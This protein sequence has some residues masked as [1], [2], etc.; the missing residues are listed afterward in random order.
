M[1]VMKEIIDRIRKQGKEFY[2]TFLDLEKAYDTVN[3]QKL[4]KL[5]RHI[6]VDWKIIEVIKQMHMNKIRFTIGNITTE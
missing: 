1:N 5:L 2:F 6:G 4:M 3:G